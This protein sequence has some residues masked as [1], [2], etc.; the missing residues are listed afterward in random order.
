MSGKHITAINGINTK[1]AM[2]RMI[3][4]HF[5]GHE[6]SYKYK[7]SNR[8][9]SEIQK[10]SRNFYGK[11]G[12]YGVHSSNMSKKHDTCEVSQIVQCVQ[13]INCRRGTERETGMAQIM[14][15]C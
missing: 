12:K 15:I 3:H 4:F 13:R 1:E 8:V 9:F 2:N 10:F 5:K 6:N 7:L 14:K 11:G